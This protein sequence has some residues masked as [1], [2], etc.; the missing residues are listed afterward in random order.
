MLLKKIFTEIL[1]HTHTHTHTHTRARAR[2][3][4]HAR[5]HASV[6]LKT[7]EN[8]NSSPTNINCFGMKAM[9]FNRMDIDNSDLIPSLIEHKFFQTCVS[10]ESALSFLSTVRE[11][12]R[13][14][15]LL[16]IIFN[17]ARDVCNAR[18]R[19]QISSGPL[20]FPVIFQSEFAFPVE[21]P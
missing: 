20:H 7:A 11:R 13:E 19:V 14:R 4:T 3:R 21:N 8:L 5:T 17:G 9:A 1:T 16:I 10:F 12:E 18:R 2:A 15:R 6:W